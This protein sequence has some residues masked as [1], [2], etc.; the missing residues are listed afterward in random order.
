MVAAP[1]G[2]ELQAGMGL[3][4]T[5]GGRPEHCTAVVQCKRALRAPGVRKGGR[6]ARVHARG[7][8]SPRNQALPTPTPLH[9]HARHHAARHWRTGR[10]SRGQADKVCFR[11]CSAGAARLSRV[12]SAQGA[13]SH[14]LVHAGGAVGAHSH[15]VCW[16]VHLCGRRLCGEDVILPCSSSIRWAATRTARETAQVPAVAPPPLANTWPAEDAPPCLLACCR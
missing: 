6:R 12:S 1:P 5:P 11:L 15:H 13:A 3:P 4:A 14:A 8:I 9:P 16:A 2:A 10:A 7:R